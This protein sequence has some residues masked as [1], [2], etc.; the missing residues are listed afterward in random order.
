MLFPVWGF[1]L[2]LACAGTMA[3]VIPSNGSDHSMHHQ[4][5]QIRFRAASG[6]AE[7][8]PEDWLNDAMHFVHKQ[9]AKKVNTNRAKN[10]ILFLGDGMSVATLSATRVYMGGEELRLSFEDFPHMGMSKTY[11]VDYQVADSACSSTAY[12]S[13]VKANYGTLGVTAS[14]PRGDCDLGIDPQYHTSSIAA[15]AMAAGKSAGLVTTTRVTHASPAGV[16]AH[17]ADREW[18]NNKEVKDSPCKQKFVDD[19]AKQMIVGDVGPR[20]KVIMGGGRREFRDKSVL[21]EEQTKG[22]RTDGRDLI[23]EW[24]ELKWAQSDRKTYVW[25]KTELMNVDPNEVDYLLGLFEASHCKY[26]LDIVDDGVEDMEPSLSEMV[27]K[28]IDVL[29][30][31]GNGFFLFVEGGRID[32]GHH[33][34]NAHYAVDETAEFARAIALAKQKLGDDETLIVVTADHSHTMT[35]AG[36][37]VSQFVL[38]KVAMMVIRNIQLQQRRG[39]ILGPAGISN[40]DRKPYMTLSYANGPGSVNNHNPELTLTDGMSQRLNPLLLDYKNKEFAYPGILPLEK[41][42]HGGD[43]VVIYATGPWSHLF[44]G[45][46]E[47]S[48]LPHMMAYASCIGDGLKMCQ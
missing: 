35:Y 2:T 20:L 23:E 10:V 46:I 42:T 24:K 36:Y 12:L 1:L 34:A 5:Y 22:K 27:D 14:V 6:L 18:E 48:A 29:S 28:A 25:N 30:K 32:H 43:D 8:S 44:E 38:L 40:R 41:E 39:S 4:D 31:D 37:S 9:T 26:N 13:G 11:C 45:S 7:P 15:W 19:I 21:D 3:R 17:I 33:A 16:Y 47:Q